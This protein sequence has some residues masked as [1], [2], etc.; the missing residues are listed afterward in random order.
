MIEHPEHIH[1][2]YSNQLNV[3][4]SAAFE[5]HYAE[6]FVKNWHKTETVDL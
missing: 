6:Q 4:L 2:F 5:L 1:T 3:P